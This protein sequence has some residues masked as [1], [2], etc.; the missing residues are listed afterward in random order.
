MYG[1]QGLVGGSVSFDDVDLSLYIVFCKGNVLRV[2][3][4][5]LQP[6]EE[7]E[8]SVS[9]MFGGPD[10][11]ARE[12]LEWLDAFEFYTLPSKFPLLW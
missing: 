3:V 4:A 12:I 10:S 9:A 6:S 11:Y 2:N 8:G 5:R 1:V 7:S